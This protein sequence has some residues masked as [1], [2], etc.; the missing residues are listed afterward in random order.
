MAEERDDGY[1]TDNQ[2]E[3]S[4]IEPIYEAFV[5]PLTKQVM[6]DPVTIEN[7]QTFE[8]AA[9]EKWFT[10]CRAICPLTHKELSSTD[11]NPSIA[12]RNTIEECNQRNEAIQLDTACKSL[13]HG[14][15]ED[16]VLQALISIKNLCQKNQS[17][18]D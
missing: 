7:G 3:T 5:R 17:M 6:A 8:R 11:L 16:E 12:L 18:K 4:H 2:I 14:N 15:A 9:T 13:S 1:D 10:E